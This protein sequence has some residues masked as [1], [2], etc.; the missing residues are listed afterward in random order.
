[1]QSS[2]RQGQFRCFGGHLGQ[3]AREAQQEGGTPGLSFYE[4]GGASCP[5]NSG[6]RAPPGLI[7]N[8]WPQ[9]GPPTLPSPMRKMMQMD[10]VSHREEVQLGGAGRVIPGRKLAPQESG[11]GTL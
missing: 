8:S 7:L 3:G 5:C 11:R 10:A 1:M 2:G 4:G 9:A 6:G